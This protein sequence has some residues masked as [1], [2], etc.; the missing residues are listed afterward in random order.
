MRTTLRA[1]ASAAAV[2]ALAL[3]LAACGGSNGAADASGAAP[4][5]SLDATPKAATVLDTP[6][7]KPDMVLT[8]T[9]G[10]TYDFAERT[11]GRPTLLFF[12]YTH[13]PDV[14]PTTMS[15]IAIAKSK[16]PAAEQEE[17]AVVFVTTDPERDTPQRLGEWLKAQDPSFVGLTGDFSTIQAGA[18]SLGVDVE[19][20]V[21]EKDGS[22]TV[23]HGAQ[24]IA[25]SPKDD[26]AHALYMSGTTSEEFAADLPKIIAGRTQ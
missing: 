10:K 25:Y 1:A 14:C 12:G 15:D 8:D 22:V 9:H 5:V 3:T 19:A 18:R 17:L 2:A 24:V 13:C 11:K 6:F 23:T 7:E 20:P 21:K 4:V 16:L 26:K